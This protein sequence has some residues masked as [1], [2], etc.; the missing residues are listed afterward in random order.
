MFIYFLFIRHRI[1]ELPRPIALKLTHMIDIWVCFV[2][3]V[4][5]IWG[6]SSK[7]FGAKNM[8][9]LGL[10][11]ATSD[12]DR[13]YLRNETRYPKLERR[14]RERFLPHSAKEVW[15]TLFHYPESRTCEF[16]ATQINFFERPYFC[17]RVLAPQIFTCARHSP[18]LADA[19]HKLGRGLPK[20]FKGRHLKL[21]LKFSMFMTITLGWWE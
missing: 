6:L 20:N 5:K 2:M 15:W 17:P 9:N 1:S 4:Q 21:G 13:E 3:K 8:G 18:R 14:D 19:H 10:F 7:K 11:F 12:F 16:V